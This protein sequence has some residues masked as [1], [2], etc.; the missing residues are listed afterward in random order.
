LGKFEFVEL[1]SNAL[2]ALEQLREKQQRTL[3]MEIF[4]IFQ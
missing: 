1:A 4:S 2:A 3:Q